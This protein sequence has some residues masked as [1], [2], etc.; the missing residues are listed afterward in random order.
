MLIEYVVTGSKREVSDEVGIA[1]VA[2]RIARA[3]NP[4]PEAA[5]ETG[6]YGRKDMR[7]EPAAHTAASTPGKP[8]RKYKR[9]DLRPEE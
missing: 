6:A 9:R 2:R 1:L 8:T 4:S 7:P 3:V 5:S